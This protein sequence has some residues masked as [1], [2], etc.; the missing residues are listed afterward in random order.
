M[1][2]DHFLALASLNSVYTSQHFLPAANGVLEHLPRFPSS[3][4]PSAMSKSN[5]SGTGSSSPPPQSAVNDET[6]AQDFENL[7]T[8]HQNCDHLQHESSVTD[9]RYLKQDD[10]EIEVEKPKPSTDDDSS[11]ASG[12]ISER[13]SRF[14]FG[15]RPEVT[16]TIS[17]V[18]DGI[19]SRHDVEAASPL[20]KQPTPRHLADPNLVT[21]SNDDP[22]NPKTW[23]MKQKWAAVSVVSTFTLISP[24]SSTMTA[25][26]LNSI[27][28]ELNITNEFEKQLSLSIFVLGKV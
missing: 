8:E 14:E 20:E 21:W 16:R 4:L 25:P 22:E 2:Q 1:Q 18:R 26:A 15:R 12:S 24:V 6:G 3:I 23:S 5:E 10:D 7:N 17:D 11:S 27:A 13:S 28:N 9:A 19:E